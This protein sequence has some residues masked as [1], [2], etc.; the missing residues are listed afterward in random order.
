M[1]SK[2]HETAVTYALK[3]DPAVVDTH[4]LTVRAYVCCLLRNFVAR[5]TRHGAPGSLEGWF[6]ATPCSTC[7][8]SS[9]IKPFSAH[10]AGSVATGTCY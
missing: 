3:Y 5:P 2:C 6:A 4:T 7:P 1:V 10:L 8:R 9:C